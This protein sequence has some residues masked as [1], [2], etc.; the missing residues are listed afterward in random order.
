LLLV[1]TGPSGLTG[2]LARRHVMAAEE[3]N[4]VAACTALAVKA[5]PAMRSRSSNA[6]LNLVQIG[7]SGPSSIPAHNL[8]AVV[9]R[10][11]TDPAKGAMIAKESQWKATPAMRIL[12]QD[13]RIIQIGRLAQPVAAKGLK[14]NNELAKMEMTVLEKAQFL[15]IAI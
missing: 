8:A 12:V 13:G 1:R 14:Q 9:S 3:D 10:N 4:P 2:H 7:R 11:G 6:I 15:P 5:D